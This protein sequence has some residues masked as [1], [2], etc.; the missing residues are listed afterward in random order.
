M[1]QDDVA[2]ASVEEIGDNAIT[3]EAEAANP[4]RARARSRSV[5]DMPDHVGQRYFVE[6]RGLRREQRLFE[7]AHDAAPTI[8]DLGHRLIVATESA[9]VVRDLL[10]IAQHRGWETIHVTGS[11][12]FRRMVEQEA[13]EHG[14]AVARPLSPDRP[15]P[16]NATNQAPRKPAERQR[17]S[18]D[19]R[20][21][22]AGIVIESGEAPFNGRPGQ[23]PS[24]YVDLQLDDGR[25]RR[26]WGAGLPAAL[27]RVRIEL[28]DAI[29]L[30]EDGTE[31]AEGSKRPRKRWVAERQPELG[32]EKSAPV[33]WEEAAPKGR[34]RSDALLLGERFRRG[35]PRERAEDPDLRP[36]QSQ[37]V[38][39]KALASAYLVHNP[40]AAALVASR[41][42]DIIASSLDR[43]GR[44]SIARMRERGDGRHELVLDRG[45][46]R[47]RPITS[48]P[49][50]ERHPEITKVRDRGRRR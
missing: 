14:V 43:G 46:E 31:R 6:E 49:R 28:G 26:A 33:G 27:A 10:D 11:D 7:T 35:S 50:A 40:V 15:S 20:T 41:F 44:F 39:A 1:A 2:V 25:I 32:L 37:L 17:S 19:F 9:A 18:G 34:D 29:L 3:P 36:A 23:R 12:R 45:T 21:G 13:L 22:V 42:E 24:P 47:D 16:A 5:G 8:R 4:A 38:A 48:K 30:R